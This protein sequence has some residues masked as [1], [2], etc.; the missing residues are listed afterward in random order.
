[1]KITGLRNLPDDKNFFGNYSVALYETI[2]NLT[3]KTGHMSKKDAVL[4][5]HLWME[6]R[7]LLLR[8]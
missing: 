7:K 8:Y 1:L 4:W 3:L 2:I 6:I 5:L